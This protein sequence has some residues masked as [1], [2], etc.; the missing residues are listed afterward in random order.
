MHLEIITRSAGSVSKPVPLVF[1]HGAWHGL[2]CWDQHFLPF[3]AD[4]G[5]TAIAFDLRGHGKSESRR[6]LRFT[7]TDHYVED[8]S[9][10]IGDLET[11]PVLVGHS[12]GG[13]IVQRY[14]ENHD[15]PG[16]ILLAPIPVG[17]VAGA[18]ARV[19]LRHPLALTRANLLLRLWPIVSTPKLARDAF[20]PDDMSEA[21]SDR[22]WSQLQD[23]SYL[24]FLDMLALRRPRPKR[25][26]AP[27]LVIGGGADR[28]FS[29]REMERTAKAYGGRAVM[30]PDAAHDLMLDGRWR[31]V[32]EAML[33]WLDARS[34]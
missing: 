16:A 29:R 31:Q 10:V 5:Y 12:M 33:A 13:L 19:A 32:A 21:D 22:Y 4:A 2:W 30:I 28:L 18:T 6:P 7:R 25:V 26:D 24:A 14:L 27:V 17:G 15:V 11:P 34:L 3:F 23:E 9:R 1:I 20:F 8:L